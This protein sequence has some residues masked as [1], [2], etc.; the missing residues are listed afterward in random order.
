MR[1][2][3][4]EISYYEQNHADY[5]RPIQ[6]E[7]DQSLMGGARSARQPTMDDMERAI[8]LRFGGLERRFD[9]L[10]E[11]LLNMFSDRPANQQG[12]VVSSVS[13]RLVLSTTSSTGTA[14]QW[15]HT[16]P[17]PTEGSSGHPLH[18][19]SEAGNIPADAFPA[20]LNIPCVRGE[21]ENAWRHWVSHW[22]EADPSI[23]LVKPLR[24]WAPEWYAGQSRSKFGVKYGQRKRVA[25]EFIDG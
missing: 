10:E 19:M 17:A 15:Q 25:L 11:R 21:K 8:D 1:Y 24:D 4:D 9:R 3:F 13:P 5:L 23:G 16:V 18:R 6:L 14:L 2:L 7:L 12:L 20:N 22:E